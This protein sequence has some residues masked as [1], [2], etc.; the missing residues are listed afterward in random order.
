MQKPSLK[1]IEAQLIEIREQL[2]IESNNA[3]PARKVVLDEEIDKVDMILAGVQVALK[4]HN[5]C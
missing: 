4:N 1:P 3:T 2:V 5:L